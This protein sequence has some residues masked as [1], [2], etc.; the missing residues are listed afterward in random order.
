MN[1]TGK[2]ASNIHTADFTVD[3]SSVEGVSPVGEAYAKQNIIDKKTP[4]LACEGVCIRGEIARLAANIVAQELP[5]YARACHA[6]TF[7]VP[8]SSMSGWING[9]DKVLMIDGCF[10]KCHGRVLQNLTDRDKVIHIEAL[11]LYRKYNDIFLVDDVPE[12]ERKAVAR[13]VADQI[14][15]KIR[16]NSTLCD[17]EYGTKS[18]SVSCA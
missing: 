17:S 12:A 16:E 1:E 2:E 11:P 18:C 4:V 6:E 14:M 13:Q 3:V 7:F 5:G 15:A 10:L 9:S 8:Y